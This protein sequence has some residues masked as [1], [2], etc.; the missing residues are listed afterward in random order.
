MKFVIQALQAVYVFERMVL[1]TSQCI[2]IV[3]ILHA[4]MYMTS[5][6]VNYKDNEVMS[7]V[8]KCI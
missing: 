3:I 5:V 2:L 8:T 1:Y 4:V 7:K 6:F